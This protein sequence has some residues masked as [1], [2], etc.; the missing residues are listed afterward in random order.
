MSTTEL[1]AE[2][3]A[4][5]PS[6]RGSYTLIK[7][8]ADEVERLS[9]A[10]NHWALLVNR[11]RHALELIHGS[12]CADPSLLVEHLKETARQA[13]AEETPET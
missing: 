6:D 7:R 13:L 5:P 1:I 10:T 11:Y 8:L 2:A 9:N 4:V 3:R 12:E